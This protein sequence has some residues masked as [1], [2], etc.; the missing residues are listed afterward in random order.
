MDM[1]QA[2]LLGG[3]RGLPPR[4]PCPSKYPRLAIGL[5]SPLG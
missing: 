3:M 5:W 2:G 1:A 4:Y